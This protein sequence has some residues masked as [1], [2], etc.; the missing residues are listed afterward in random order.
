M[1]M[2]HFLSLSHSFP[3]VGLDGDVFPGHG[4]ASQHVGICSI[5]SFVP[6]W[7]KALNNVYVDKGN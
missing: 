2:C 5:S 3:K 4:F 7:F 1:S 6:L